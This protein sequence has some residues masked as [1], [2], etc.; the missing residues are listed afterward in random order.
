[1]KKYKVGDKVWIIESVKESIYVVACE[2][3]GVGPKNY[4]QLINAALDRSDFY[5]KDK[6]IFDTYN[7]ACF[8]ALELNKKIYNQN[9]REIHKKTKKDCFL[10]IK[11]ST[12]KDWK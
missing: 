4:H 11:N 12:H 5:R 9:R 8:K 10:Y 1:M 7:I 6:D 2:I 3:I